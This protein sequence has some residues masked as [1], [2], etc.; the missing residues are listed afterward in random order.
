[1]AKAASR[2]DAP[3]AAAAPEA[4]V[5]T[6]LRRAPAELETAPAQELTAQTL[7]P[8]PQPLTLAVG[9]TAMA[10]IVDRRVPIERM[11][12]YRADEGGEHP[13]AALRLRNDTGSSLP[14]GLVTL[15]EALPAGGMTYLG[16]APLP[17]TA[18]GR[19]Q[20]LAYG[21]DGPSTSP[22]IAKCT[23][24]SIGRRWSTAC[25]S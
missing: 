3:L 22:S 7:F 4:D 15:Y 6:L 8:L 12:L 9:H 11:A 21:V 20:T 2:A 5:A 24:G 10:P 19:D 13:S 25:S 23:R 17:Q 16:D 14:P 18:A 1:M